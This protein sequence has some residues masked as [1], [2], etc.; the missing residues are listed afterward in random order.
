MRVPF[1]H[2]HKNDRPAFTWRVMKSFVTS[3]VS[4]SAATGALGLS[5]ALRLCDRYQRADG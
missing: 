1:H 2:Q 4:S 3:T 5:S